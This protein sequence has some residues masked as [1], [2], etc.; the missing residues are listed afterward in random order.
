MGFGVLDHEGAAIRGLSIEIRAQAGRSVKRRKITFGLFQFDVGVNERIYQL[1]LDA[2]GVFAHKDDRHGKLYGTHEHIGDE[3][4]PCPAE[5]AQWDF[6]QGLVYF[7]Q[8]IN[9]TLSG[10]PLDPFEFRLK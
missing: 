4:E 5:S 1:Q 8:R 6:Q 3:A 9:L 7:A 10:S 2:P